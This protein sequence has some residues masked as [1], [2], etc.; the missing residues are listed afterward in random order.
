MRVRCLGRSRTSFMHDQARLAQRQL[1]ILFRVFL[2]RVVDLEILSADGD[3]TKLLGQFAALLAGISLLFTAPLIVTG[4]PLPREA[5]WTMEH[6]LLAT[7]MA[8]VGLFS[9]FNWDSIFPDRSDVLVLAPLPVR[10]GTLFTAKLGALVSAVLVA[11]LALNV[12]SGLFWPL[13][14]TPKHAG[15]FGF[16][17]TFGAYWIS[18]VHAC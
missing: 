16:V 7:N 2:L 5:I 10:P 14:F 3:V 8:I 1:I 11:I 15:L 12:F 17:R 9:V 4:A 18:Q 13:L 6:L